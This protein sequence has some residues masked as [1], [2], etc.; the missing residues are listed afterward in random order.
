MTQL[1]DIFLAL[2]AFS[3]GVNA[4]HAYMQNE[5]DFCLKEIELK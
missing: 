3:T 4:M 2:V 1:H 5:I